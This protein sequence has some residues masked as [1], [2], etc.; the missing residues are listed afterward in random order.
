MK[1]IT[2]TDTKLPAGTNRCKCASC[3]E[4]FGGV[5]AFE[6]HRVGPTDDRSCLAPAGMRDRHLRP[7]LR[8]NSRGY[9]VRIF[10]GCERS[11]LRAA[12]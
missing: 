6:V 8:L 4:Y 3:G 7:L 10:E 12:S 2:Q 1:S 11:P 9:L 5:R